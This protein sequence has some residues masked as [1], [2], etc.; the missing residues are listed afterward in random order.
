MLMRLR[1]FFISQ[2]YRGTPYNGMRHWI[3]LMLMR[4]PEKRT[5]II[6]HRISEYRDDWYEGYILY[7]CEMRLCNINTLKRE[8]KQYQSVIYLIFLIILS[9]ISNDKF[10]KNILS[11]LSIPQYLQYIFWYILYFRVMKVFQVHN[12][13]C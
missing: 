5:A 9:N 1:F 3:M 8:N 4:T 2:M 13:V 12:D 6:R 7:M 11:Y 10:F